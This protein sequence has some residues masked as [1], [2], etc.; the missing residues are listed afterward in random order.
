MVEHIFVDSFERTIYSSRTSIDGPNS[1]MAG[2]R[3]K[4]TWKVSGP[5]SYA[6]ILGTGS[7]VSKLFRCIQSKNGMHLVELFV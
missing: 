6:T 4:K 2:A 1:R 3:I 5:P 7:S